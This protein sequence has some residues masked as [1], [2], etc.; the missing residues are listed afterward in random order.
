MVIHYSIEVLI[1]L[2]ES[3]DTHLLTIP[4]HEFNTG[5]ELIYKPQ[6]GQSAIG[7]AIHRCKGIGVTTLL[8][9]TVFAI[10]D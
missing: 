7:I 2:L 5:E 1:H 10:K 6:S 3:T 8:P 9:S 4:R